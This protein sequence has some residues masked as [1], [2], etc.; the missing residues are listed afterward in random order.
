MIYATSSYGFIKTDYSSNIMVMSWT[1]NSKTNEELTEDLK[2]AF[3]YEGQTATTEIKLKT[4]I[5][6][7][8]V[9]EENN[10]YQINFRKLQCKSL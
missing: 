5:T 7:T 1:G 8:Y 3:N 6:I 9:N 2:N 4:Y 10:T